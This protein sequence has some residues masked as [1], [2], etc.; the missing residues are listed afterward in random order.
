M[1]YGTE[2]ATYEDVPI[3]FFFDFATRYHRTHDSIA[4]PKIFEVSD[5]MIE[6]FCA[7][8]DERE[9]K[10]ETETSKFFADML[11][12]AK[13]EDLDE[14][15]IAQ[16]EAL[17]PMLTPDFRA[18]IA[19]NKE[20][21]KQFLGSELVLRYYYQKGQAAYNLKFDKELKRAIQQVK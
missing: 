3:H 4:E 14:A 7:F 16:L 5:E 12:M 17:E 6:E 15:T 8:L 2:L 13:N 11:R 18:A 9:F 20:E 1:L 21:I 19:R 10:Y